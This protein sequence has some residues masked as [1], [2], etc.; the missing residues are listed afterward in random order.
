MFN[1]R[2]LTSVLG[3][4]RIPEKD[5]SDDEARFKMYE[6]KGIYFTYTKF[7]DVYFL[8][9]RIDMLGFSYMDYGYEDWYESA[10]KFNG[11]RSI[12]IYEFKNV[13]DNVRKGVDNLQSI[14]DTYIPDIEYIT[15]KYEEEVKVAIES[16]N[17]VKAEYKW[18]KADKYK[19]M[20]VCK[21]LQEAEE[22]EK[23][24]SNPET[25]TNF[26]KY[27]KKKLRELEVG[28]KLRGMSICYSVKYLSVF[29]NELFETKE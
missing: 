18:R 9:V 21:H 6:Y 28:S 22:L 26:S 23:K 1:A 7:E 25:K 10:Q 14:L 29:F 12:D 11:T 19:L 16:A 2:Q 13:L 15:K 24:E 8:A 5:F 4:V 17:R 20:E 3:A 27:P